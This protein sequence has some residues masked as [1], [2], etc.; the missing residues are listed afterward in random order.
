VIAAALANLRCGD[1]RPLAAIAGGAGEGAGTA[2][3]GSS[4]DLCESLSAACSEVAGSP[5]A[6]SEPTELVP[7]DSLP[8]E[9]V[10]QNAHNN[11]D[12]VWHDERVYVVF[13]AA[14]DH[15]AS[16][17][18]VMV[19]M[20]SDDHVRWRLET[21]LDFDTDLRE[22]RFLSLNGELHLFF[23]VLG[24]NPLAFE[25]QGTLVTTLS[26]ERGWSEPEEVLPPGFILW[27]ARNLKGSG[28]AYVSG[29]VGG[30]ELYAEGTGSL[31]VYLLETADA[32]R[33]EPVSGDGVVLS[34]G[35]SETDFALLE[36]G[37]LV[38][39]S[40]N[41]VGDELGFGSKICRAP[42]EALGS[43]ECAADVKKYDSP[44][45]FR[46][47]PDV[48]LLARRNA[49]PSGAFDLEQRELS[50]EDQR[51]TYLL[52]YWNTPKRCA[53]WR[54]DPE[55]LEVTH[56][57][58]LPSAGDTCFPALL[59]LNSERYLVYD[60]TSPTEELDLKWYEGQAGPTSI[61]HVT[62]KLEPA[63]E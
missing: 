43:W 52:E 12:V 5:P 23:A 51:L 26:P 63:A 17:D 32:R 9:I 1:D 27:R 40:R 59:R 41:E 42:A 3:A 6:I 25:P 4:A 19:V 21:E 31:E 44:L 61:Q 11:L 53:L 15:F 36:S 50:A 38:A 57:L 18:V 33:F 29:Y 49:T 56:L 60:Y 54:V 28:M 58:D 47:G 55:A 46:H 39:V 16:S 35:S 62:L 24:D 8:P 48:Y 34:G 30:D 37:D 20:S 10:T 22:P 45:V 7:S 14:P 13:R 2:G